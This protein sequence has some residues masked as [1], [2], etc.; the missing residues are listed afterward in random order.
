MLLLFYTTMNLT[1]MALQLRLKEIKPKSGVLSTG[2]VSYLQL[3][4]EE[5]IHYV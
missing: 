4:T 1:A 2:S 3:K 5:G